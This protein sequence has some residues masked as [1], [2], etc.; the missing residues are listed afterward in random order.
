[1]QVLTHLSDII[2]PMIIFFVVGYGVVSGI[3]VY[4]TFLKG[5]K[6]GLKVV[7]DIMPTLIGLMVGVGVL[8]ASGFFEV[9]GKLLGP[10][11][12]KVGLPAPIVPLLIVKMFSSSAATGLVLDIFKTTGPDSYAGMVA[13]ILMSCTETIFYTMSVYFLA[14]KVTKTRYTLTGALL[15][16]LAGMVA[17]I[18]LAGQMV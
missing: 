8:R 16:T 14:A 11:T 9:L 18:F 5:A 3:K 17:S 15:A 10:L 12:E 7:V 13:S 4:E 6:D 2:I 1:M